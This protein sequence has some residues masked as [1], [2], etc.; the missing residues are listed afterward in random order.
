ME[1][2]GLTIFFLRISLACICYT[3]PSLMPTGERDWNDKQRV[4]MSVDSEIERFSY[5]LEMKTRL[6]NVLEK[7]LPLG[8]LFLSRI[9]RF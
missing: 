7:K 1:R 2:E 6:L 8:I 5:D 9:T 3:F 4:K